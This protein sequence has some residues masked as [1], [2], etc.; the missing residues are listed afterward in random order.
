ME[1]L[2]VIGCGNHYASILAPSIAILEALGELSLLATVDIRPGS[3]LHPSIEHPVLHLVRKPEQPLSAILGDFRKHDPVVFLGHSHEWHTSDAADLL[4]AG[5]RVIIEKPY[6][7]TYD[8]LYTLRGLLQLFPGRVALAEYY[9]MMKA[10]PLMHSAALLKQDSYLLCEPGFLVSDEAIESTR[11]SIGAIGRPRMV[12]CDI[13]EGHGETGRFDHRG[14]QYADARRGGGIILDL[15][16]HALAPLLALEGIV[17]EIPAR[18]DLEVRSATAESYQRFA[19]ASCAVPEEHIPETYSEIRLET[20]YGV[21]VVISIGKYVLPN[22]NQRRLVIVGDTGIAVLDLSS[23]SLAIG[24]G[25]ST[26]V[27]R[28]TS[29]KRPES[30]YVPVLRTS[31]A[32]LSGVTPYTFDATEVAVRSQELALEA[33]IASA[34]Y[35]RGSRPVYMDSALPGTILR[36]LPITGTNQERP[37][38]PAQEPHGVEPAKTYYEHQYARI[39]KLEEQGFR[40]SALALSVTAAV[41]ALSTRSSTETALVAW[42]YLIGVTLLANVIAGLYVLRVN[43]SIVVHGRR[44]KETLSRFAPEEA[45]IDRKH[46]QW[47]AG[48]M[49]ARPFLQLVLHVALIVFAILELG[50][51][52]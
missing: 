2:V 36:A 44:A 42:P 48:R 18:A 20:T 39:E 9:L 35:S 19:R 26:P 22:R 52:V 45:L 23:C 49:G 15:G 27:V 8:Q 29:P 25:E 34:R 5:F 32:C 17:G 41:L 16:V 37:C 28:L 11:G 14:A 47:F 6:A 50:G 51:W 33:R 46:K 43:H 38:A 31:I 3:G 4:S 40:M 7:I 24:Q 13:L 10:T 1:N 30:R 12:Y 21:P